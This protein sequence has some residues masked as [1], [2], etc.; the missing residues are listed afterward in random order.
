MHAAVPTTPPKAVVSI[1]IL[2]AKS[3]VQFNRC[4][5]SAAAVRARFNQNSRIV[6]QR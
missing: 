5:A 1:A 3:I 2:R 4:V 6:N